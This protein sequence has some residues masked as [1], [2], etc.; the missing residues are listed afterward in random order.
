MKKAE[1][2]AGNLME[3]F[4]CFCKLNFRCALCIE[5]PIHCKIED[6]VLHAHTHL[7]TQLRRLVDAC[8]SPDP[9]DRPDIQQVSEVAQ[10]MHRA[11]KT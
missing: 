2:K 7:H 8:I 1:N 3:I 11:T 5:H 6:V 10:R 9:D 4:A